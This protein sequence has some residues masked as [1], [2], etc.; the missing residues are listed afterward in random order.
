MRI[1]FANHEYIQRIFLLP[2]QNSTSF[3]Q[4]TDRTLKNNL[5]LTFQAQL[6]MIVEEAGFPKV[7]RFYHFLHSCL[8]FKQTVLFNLR[9][10]DS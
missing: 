8:D 2:Q 9:P 10:H 6:E 7:L 5:R 3:C 4:H 1:G